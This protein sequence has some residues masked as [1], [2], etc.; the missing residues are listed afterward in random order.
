MQIDAI[1]AERADSV[2]SF[3]QLYDGTVGI[4]GCAALIGRRKA[5]DREKLQVLQAS[6]RSCFDRVE[7]FIMRT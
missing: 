7:A 6:E 5:I 3:D 4:A 2:Q 1:H